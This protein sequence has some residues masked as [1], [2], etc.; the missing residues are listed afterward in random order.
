MCVTFSPGRAYTLHEA[1]PAHAKVTVRQS[2]W[3]KVTSDA[4]GSSSGFRSVCGI[5]HAASERSLGAQSVLLPHDRGP[6]RVLL[7][8]RRSIGESK[9]LPRAPRRRLLPTDFALDSKRFAGHARGSPRHR[10]TGRGATG[11][12]IRRRR[13]CRGHWHVLHRVYAGTGGDRAT[14]VCH[15]LRAAELSLRRPTLRMAPTIQ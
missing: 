9:A 7:L 11:L 10:G 15:A 5:D 13:V 4:R 2:K 3:C 1:A 14:A 12:R 6:C 8:R